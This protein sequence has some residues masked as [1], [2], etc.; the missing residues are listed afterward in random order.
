MDNCKR[1][2]IRKHPLCI[3]LLSGIFEQNA[4]LPRPTERHLRVHAQASV[5]PLRPPVSDKRTG[6]GSTRTQWWCVRGVE[7][8]CTK[9]QNQKVCRRAPPT[10]DLYSDQ[11]TR[12]IYRSRASSAPSSPQKIPETITPAAAPIPAPTTA[13]AP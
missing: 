7:P 9:P 13:A 5:N 1:R 12:P 4:K 3:R 8:G 10:V 2:S 11:L 6:A